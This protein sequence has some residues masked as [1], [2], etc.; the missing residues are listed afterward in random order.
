[1]KIIEPGHVYELELR[2]NLPDDP[3]LVLYFVNREEGTEHA[4]TTTQEVLKALI[5]RVMHCDNQMRWEGNDKIIY[6]LRMA[7]AFQEARAILRKTHQGMLKIEDVVTGKD[8]HLSLSSK[9]LG[10]DATLYT[11]RVQQGLKNEGGLGA[12]NS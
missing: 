8:G 1:M 11:V 6:H 10:P 9:T 12:G 7:I 4:G 5:D 2:D 3:S